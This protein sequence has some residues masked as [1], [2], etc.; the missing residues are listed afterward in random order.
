M[1]RQTLIPAN[2]G[3]LAGG[4]SPCQRPS[5]RVCFR[6][7]GCALGI[8]ESGPKCRNSSGCREGRRVPRVPRASL[9]CPPP[10]SLLPP[11][12]P[13]AHCA[14]P[15]S[16]DLAQGQLQLAQLGREAGGDGSPV[17][18]PEGQGQ[19]PVA[20]VRYRSH[21]QRR[22][23]TE[24]RGGQPGVTLLGDTGT[25]GGVTAGG[26]WGHLWVTLLG[27]GDTPG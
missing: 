25:P 22:F 7:P 26:A 6:D 5:F 4:S 3:F 1:G 16:P 9:P 14:L 12:P 2:L 27:W 21:G 17:S 10:L 20:A 13:A 23:S 18:P 15:L 11:S 19:S 8:Q 24:V